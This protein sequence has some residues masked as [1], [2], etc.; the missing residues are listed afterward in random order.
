M[1]MPYFSPCSTVD[2]K[3]I[4]II[5][6][7]KRAIHILASKCKILHNDLKWEHVGVRRVGQDVFAYIFD[8]G[9]IIVISEN[10]I[11]GAIEQME[12]S[13]NI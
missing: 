5:Q 1:I 2:R 13:L 11:A 10:D 3:D 7:V 4:K 6:A 12:C 9:T 8:F